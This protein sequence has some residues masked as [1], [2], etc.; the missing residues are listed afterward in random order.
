MTIA[1]LS[2]LLGLLAVGASPAAA[3]ELNAWP[4]YVAQKAPDGTVGSWD[5]AGPLFFSE[6]VPA[7]DAGTAEGFR[8]IYI[9]VTGGGS[10]R[11]DI[12]YPLFFFR[13]YPGAYKWSILQLINGE[14]LDNSVARAGGPTDRHFDIWP[15]YF[16]HYT[17]DPIDTYHALLPIYG[18]VK[19]RL[20]Y[21]KLQ[22]VLFPLYVETRKRHT[23]TNYYPYPIIRNIHGDENGFAVW[24]LFNVSTGPEHTHRYSF[25]WPLIWNN[26]LLPDTDEPETAEHHHEE[27]FLPFYTKTTKQG[28][29]DEN[30]AWPFV[31]FTDRVTPTRYSETRYFWPFFVQG[32]GDRHDVNRWG[33]F[34]TH[35]NI[36]GTDNRWVGWPLWHVLKFTDE[37]TA[38]RK[39][40]LLYFFY[41]EL[42]ESSVSR[43]E[44]PHAYKRHLWPLFS[45]WSNGAGSRQFQF[46]SVLEV[47][48][49]ANPDIREVWGPLLTLYR[50]DHR[51]TG[52]T[53]GELLWN[54]ITW[55]RTPTAG[56]VEFHVGPLLGRV[57]RPAGDRWTILGFDFGAKLD[58][59]DKA[60]R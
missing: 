17:Q 52:E 16:S 4:A 22:W 7:P 23:T 48:F 39:T 35:S 5:A 19:Y 51:P 29:V 2:V 25:L 36:K 60:N 59:A 45:D 47:F 11:T 34:Y 21:S 57:R 12:L 6:Q 56:L 49:P 41:W 33:P 18:R 37:D 15:F 9:R 10:I 54:A 31:G 1:R 30:F 32:R 50:Y 13:R 28:S 40:Q 38:Q 3:Y 44:L 55:R 14:G 20:G 27:G 26:E 8:P 58:H 42:D 43:P 46:P 53:R 24:P